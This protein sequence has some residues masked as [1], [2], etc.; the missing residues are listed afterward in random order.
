LGAWWATI[1]SAHAVYHSQRRVLRRAA[2]RR[3]GNSAVAAQ[4]VMSTAKSCIRES[5]RSACVSIPTSAVGPATY[6]LLG[7]ERDARH[8]YGVLGY[9]SSWTRI[10]ARRHTLLGFGRTS[11]SNTSHSEIDSRDNH[12]DG[13]RTETDINHRS[14]RIMSI[15]EA[16]ASSTLSTSSARTIASPSA[17]TNV[18]R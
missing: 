3:A 4:A 8:R 11:E 18:V 14:L 5:V 15:T 9:F 10:A 13:E 6:E 1:A 2:G 12:D 16:A 17:T 7:A